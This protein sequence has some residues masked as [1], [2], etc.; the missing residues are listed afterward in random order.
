MESLA[1]GFAAAFLDPVGL[2]IFAL[3]LLGG[4]VFGA[5]PGINAITLAAIVLPFTAYLQPAHA[6]MLFGVMYV[7]GVYGG[8]V[9]AILFNI[10]GSENNA[11]TA[12]DGY[13][14]TQNGQAGRAIGA[15][16][17]CSALGGIASAILM[18]I[19]T[20]P[21]AAWAVRAFG[22]PEILAL[23]IFGLSVA[24]TV[25][26]RSALKGWLSVS[27]GLLIATIGTSPGG[28]IPRYNFGSMYLMGGIQFV[29]VL[30]GVF[31]VSE[32][33]AQGQKSGAALAAHPKVAI[34]FPRLVEFW[35]LRVAMLR[36]VVIGFFAGLLP[37]IGA[38]LAAFLSYSEAVRWS[39]TPERFG[40]GELEGVVSSETANNAATGAAMIPLLALGI[41]GGAMT[42]MMLAAFQIHG[43][44]PGPAL[45]RTSADLVWVVF[46]AMLAANCAIFLL[47]WLETKTVVHLLRIPFWLLAPTILLLA[48]IGAYAGRNLMLDVWVMY[49]AGILG[50]LLRRSGF[51][52][53]GIVLGVILG[54]VG[55][56]ALVKAM[57]IV[58]YD[59]MTFLQRP[60]CLVLV[61][62]AAVF[63]AMSIVR[64]FHRPVVAP[65]T[66]KA[67]P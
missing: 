30:L 45:F 51:S 4:L 65:S 9:T 35:R 28:G 61:A 48:T 11:P 29:P 38:T 20:E 2:G 50:F 49:I 3:A 5:I 13:P 23:V 26:A 37:G 67:G 58:R 60:I 66:R 17:T 6:I 52:M 44:D 34:D 12:F 63:V 19:A 43:I 42:A 10:P 47:G 41:P 57:P 22:P 24:G 15:A 53:A 39:R 54:K 1:G 21:L 59:I 33:L 62:A 55:E 46:A 31:A 36:S 25:G 56:Q 7:S 18:M 40:K 27:L 14:M 64:S 16:V 8:A 32:V